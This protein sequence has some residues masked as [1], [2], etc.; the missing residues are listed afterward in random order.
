MCSNWWNGW[1]GF[2]KTSLTR[3]AARKARTLSTLKIK[4]PGC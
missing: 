4:T 1:D 3:N 2:F